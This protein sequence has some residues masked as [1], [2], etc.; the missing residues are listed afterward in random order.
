ML[1]YFHE[2]FTFSDDIIYVKAP[3]MDICECENAT[4]SAYELSG[5]V[6]GP[7]A[8][9]MV[10][11]GDVLKFMLSSPTHPFWIK[12][13]NGTGRNNSVSSGI[14]GVGQGKTFGLLIWD[15][16]EIMA[17]TYYYQYE[18]HP[19][20]VGKIIVRSKT[21]NNIMINVKVVP[22]SPKSPNVYE[23]SGAVSGKNAYI[24]IYKGDVA[25]FELDINGTHPFWIKTEKGTGMDN[26]VSSG[27]SGVGQG[28]TSG[29]LIWDTAHTNEST[30][31]YECE[32]HAGM[33]GLIRVVPS[34]GGRNYFN[35]SF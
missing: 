25:K 7:N 32:H 21:P 12:T 17:G 24:E 29:V 15:T 19:L 33:G 6:D 18:F 8:D 35:I 20:M 13:E 11:K 4:V 16:K 28:N 22:N 14:S 26:A 31:Y 30:Y 3:H 34:M 23:L 2:A 10:T 9:I 5:A 27:I 1:Q